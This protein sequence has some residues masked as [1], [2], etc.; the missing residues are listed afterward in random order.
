MIVVDTQTA[1]HGGTSIARH[2][3][4]VIFVRG[5]LPGEK[6]VQV[7][8]DNPESTKSFLTGAATSIGI[9]S[10]H[11]VP[12]QC[13]AAALGA[14][15]CDLDFADAAGSLEFKKQVVLDQLSRIGHIELDAER[16]HAEKL[17]PHSGWRTRVRLGVDNKGQVGQRKRGS[18]AVIPLSTAVCAQ[19]HPVLRDGLAGEVDALAG[20]GKIHPNADL[21]IAISDH[22]EL[23]NLPSTRSIIERTDTQRAPARGRGRKRK[24]AAQKAPRRTVL[25]GPEALPRELNIAGQNWQWSLPADAFWQGHRGATQ[26]YADIIADYIPRTDKDGCVAWDLYG[27]AGV[28]AEVLREALG[29]QDRRVVVVDY[30]S[31][32][33]TAG[34]AALPEDVSFVTGDV[35]RSV[36]TLEKGAGLHAVVLDPPRAGAGAAVIKDVAAAQPEHVVHIGC[37]P[38]AAARDL[39]YWTQQGFTIDD[40]TIVDA[41]GLTHHVELLA[42]LVRNC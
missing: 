12:S 4:R 13:P 37:D 18:R 38:A 17:E 33:T 41:F 15:C 25:G 40:L 23:H 3:G 19:L 29:G 9:P 10:P 5:A 14:G 1:A 21:V 6:Q 36:D 32:S 30:A 24:P 20:A 39:G 35:S 16:V 22:A 28:F 11:R 42:H 7:E 31:D 2:E 34:M 26:R 27:G 8:L